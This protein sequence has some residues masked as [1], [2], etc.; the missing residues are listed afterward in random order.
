MVLASTQVYDKARASFWLTTTHRA[1]GL[2][3]PYVQLADDF[4]DLNEPG[5]TEDVSCP[6]QLV[7]SNSNLGSASED[8]CLA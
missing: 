2:E 4:F 8:V 7:E 5:D 1:K 6:C 3:A